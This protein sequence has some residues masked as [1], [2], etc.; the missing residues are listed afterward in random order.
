MRLGEGIETTLSA[1]VARPYENAAYWAGVDL[2]N[3]SGRMLSVKGIQHS[4][5]PEME[6]DQAFV[7]P[8]Y[9]NEKYDG[10]E[11]RLAYILCDW[12]VAAAFARY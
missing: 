9:R 6:D 10:F 11:V 2:G 1:M 3:M 4:G 12:D 5:I 7:P 8:A